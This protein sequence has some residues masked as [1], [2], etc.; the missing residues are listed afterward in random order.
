MWPQYSEVVLVIESIHSLI[1]SFHLPPLCDDILNLTDAGPGVGVS[2]LLVRYRDAEIARILK[3]E[4]TE[5]I[6][7]EMTQVK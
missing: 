2:N 7:P 5:F 6:E 1:D 3:R 4:E